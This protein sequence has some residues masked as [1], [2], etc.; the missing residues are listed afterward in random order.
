MIDD[1]DS[2]AAE[3]LHMLGHLYVKSGDRK[4]GLVFL[5]LASHMAPAHTGILHTLIRAFILTGDVPR[6][7]NAIERLEYVQG[8]TPILSLLQSR[9]LWADGRHDDARRCFHDYLQ[10]REEG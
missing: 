7:L 3:L 10:R 4:R 9:A 8:H 5:L 2:H 1:S 6:A